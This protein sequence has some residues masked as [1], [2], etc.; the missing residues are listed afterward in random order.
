MSQYEGNGL[1]VAT[2]L[3]S[4]GM[5]LSHCCLAALGV[6]Y[7]LTQPSWGDGREKGPTYAQKL[8]K[9]LSRK[10]TDTHL[11]KVLKIVQSRDILCH[12]TL[13]FP[14]P[15][16]LASM[17][18][19]L[20]MD[21]REKKIHCTRQSIR[22]DLGEWGWWGEGWPWTHK[23]DLYISVAVS[24]AIAVFHASSSKQL[25]LSLAPNPHVKFSVSSL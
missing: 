6:P 18:R 13:S 4:T 7:C 14:P 23:L 10:W 2:N 9:S 19:P 25:M 12:L 17:Y 22:R 24:M 3:L 15:A 16:F 20:P 11:S 1:P 5:Q 8:T 21:F